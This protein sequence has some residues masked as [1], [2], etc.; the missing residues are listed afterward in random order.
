[1][2]FSEHIYT[3]TSKNGL[4]GDLN[5]NPKRIMPTTTQ[6]LPTPTPMLKKHT[7]NNQNQHVFQLMQKYKITTMHNQQKAMSSNVMQNKM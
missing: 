3:P 6:T 2:F 5:P 7:K 1:M 4:E